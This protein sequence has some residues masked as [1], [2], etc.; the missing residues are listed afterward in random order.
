MNTT[1]NGKRIIAGAL[2][3]GG[4]ALAGL[5]LKMGTAQAFDPQLESPGKVA[6]SH[7]LSPGEIRGFDPPPDP[8][9]SEPPSR[10]NPGV[11]RG[12]NPQPEPPVPPG[13][14]S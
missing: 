4:V 11:I 6:P 12:F 8:P 5:G 7:K 10:L 13:P 3:F 14:V 1:H 2:L 9:A